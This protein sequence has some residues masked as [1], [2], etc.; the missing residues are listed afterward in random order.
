MKKILVV[1]LLS[2][3]AIAAPPKHTAKRRRTKAHKPDLQQQLNIMAKH[4]QGKVAL[5]ATNMKSGATVAID[6]DQPVATASVIKLPIMV[7]TYAQIRTGKQALDAKLRLTKEN[8]VPGSGVLSALEP[9]VELSL[10]DTV[11]L[12][13]QVSDNTATDMVIDQVTIP[14]V[15]NRMKAMGLTNTYLYKKVY[16]PAEGEIPPDQKKF[17]LGKTTAREMAQ[18]M[19]SVVGC[20]TGAAPPSPTPANWNGI[21]DARLCR[22]MI[23]IMRGQQYRNMIP[24]YIETVDTSETRSAIADKVGQLDDVR[25]DVALIDTKSGPIIISAFTYDI[26]DQRWLAENAAEQL[27]ARMAKVIVN[28]WAPAGLVPPSSESGGQ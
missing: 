26:K 23:D 24:H 4:F 3:I 9:G 14:A 6:P 8:Q 15:N 18:V 12:M 13:M 28:D 27:I 7:E 21:S 5:Y 17:G 11:V 1:L 22:Q 20:S 19:A 2:S 25:N 16:K 10:R